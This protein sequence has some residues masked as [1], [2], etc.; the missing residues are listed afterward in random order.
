[1]PALFYT[2]RRKWAA[3]GSFSSL[4]EAGDLLKPL[5]PKLRPL[6]VNLPEVTEEDLTGR[7][8]FFGWA[9]RAVAFGS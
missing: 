2:V 7:G 9:T 5:L 8:G 3:P 4:V 1:M 6:C